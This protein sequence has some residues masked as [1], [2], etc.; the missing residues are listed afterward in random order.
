LLRQ[1][2]SLNPFGPARPCQEAS[3]LPEITTQLVI[4]FC[5][6]IFF[7]KLVDT[8]RPFAKKYIGLHTAKIKMAMNVKQID[9]VRELLMMEV[10]TM[11]VFPVVS[12]K[13]S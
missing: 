8:V 4:I 10:Y 12:A 7:A 3:C 2:D 9:K 1:F 6:K 5:G 13:S 11:C